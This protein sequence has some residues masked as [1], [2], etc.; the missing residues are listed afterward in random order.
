MKQKILL[1][2]IEFMTETYCGL[3]KRF[4]DGGN[5]FDFGLQE[6]EFLYGDLTCTFPLVQSNLEF[7][8]DY[9]KHDL[10]VFQQK[11]ILEYGKTTIKSLL[12]KDL[13]E[14]NSRCYYIYFSGLKLRPIN[15]DLITYA[16][17]Y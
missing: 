4:E 17:N 12:F 8:I 16:N 9:L 14:T 2:G 6:S 3:F 1:N 11:Q 15:P 13:S 5:R 7:W 10:V